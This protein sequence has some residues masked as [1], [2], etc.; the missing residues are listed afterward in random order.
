MQLYICKQVPAT[1]KNCT[2]GLKEKSV[3]LGYCELGLCL[4]CIMFTIKEDTDLSCLHT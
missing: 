3:M 1:K 4:L 2:Q